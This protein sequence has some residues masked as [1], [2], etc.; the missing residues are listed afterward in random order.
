L[1]GMPRKTGI[2]SME[3]MFSEAYFVTKIVQPYSAIFGLSDSGMREKEKEILW[4]K[5]LSSY[6]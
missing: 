5:W 4:D 1:D 3:A 6:I 2:V